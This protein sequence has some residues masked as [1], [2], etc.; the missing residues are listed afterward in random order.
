VKAQFQY[1]QTATIGFG[2]ANTGTSP[3]NKLIEGPNG[4]LFGTTRF[5][6][7]PANGGTLYTVN[8]DGSGFRVLHVF[9]AQPGDGGI[10]TYAG[11]AV[12]TNGLLY[13]V[14]DAGGIANYGTIYSIRPDGSDYRTIFHFT[15]S[16]GA[17]PRGQL[18]VADDGALIGTTFGSTIFRIEHDGSHF[19][20]LSFAETNGVGSGA[21]YQAGV[22]KGSD[23]WLYGT[24]EAGGLINP[25]PEFNDPWGDIGTVY[26]I[27]QDGGNYQILHQFQGTL[28]G[29]GAF[30]HGALL[31][32]SDGVLYG[33]T[34]KGGQYGLPPF[35]AERSLGTIFRLNRD[36][37]DYR[38]LHRFHDDTDAG[39]GPYHEL[40]EGSDGALYGHT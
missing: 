4:A 30:P 15:A 9:A 19:R 16:D 39:G 8:K 38:V 31:E 13:G 21:A 2:G 37:T 20:T 17:R 10:P 11:L 25:S 40:V 27:Q 29:D 7:S 32:A 36:G 22:I 28:F 3:Y 23:G 24:S 35:N 26:R 1:E 18:I 5:Q 33:M 12:G 14:T 34:P 6:G